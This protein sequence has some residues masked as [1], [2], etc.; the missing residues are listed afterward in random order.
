MYWVS[1]RASCKEKPVNPSAM[2]N[3]GTEFEYL[4]GKLIFGCRG[5][6]NRLYLSWEFNTFPVLY[7]FRAVLCS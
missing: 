2:K 7:V 5:R 6:S 4:A 1:R 3:H